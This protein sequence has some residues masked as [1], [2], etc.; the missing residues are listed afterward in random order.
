MGK[1]QHKRPSKSRP[2]SQR[3]YFPSMLLLPMSLRDGAAWGRAGLSKESAPFS[4]LSGVISLLSVFTVLGAISATLLLNESLPACRD[5]YAARG[6][7]RG[8]GVGF[9][10]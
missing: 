4:F 8:E 7:L 9:N 5:S 3:Q 2:Q 6:Q 10:L 1:S